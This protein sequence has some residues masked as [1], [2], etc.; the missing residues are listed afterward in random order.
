MNNEALLGPLPS[1]Y[2]PMR[3]LENKI[4]HQAFFNKRIGQLEEE[5]PRLTALQLRN[6]FPE[7]LLK[8][9]RSVQKGDPRLSVEN[10]RERGVALSEFTII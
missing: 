3:V 1:H 6:L 4:Y 9:S 10:L 8:A 2:E 5:D 7:E